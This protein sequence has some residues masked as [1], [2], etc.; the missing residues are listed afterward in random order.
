MALKD[1]EARY[2]SKRAK[3][4]KLTDGAG[5]YLLVRPNGSKLWR[6]KY[7]FGDKEKLLSFGAYPEVSLAAAR[8]RRAEAK[9]AL[10]QGSDPGG[11]AAPTPIATFE[12]AARA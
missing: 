12:A 10:A 4:Y 2:A 5:L 11:K 9:I 3:D 8:L 1:L 6:M 7:R